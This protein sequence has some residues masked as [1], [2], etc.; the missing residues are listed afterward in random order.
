MDAK[1]RCRPEE[2]AKSLASDRFCGRRCRRQIV[3]SVVLFY[4][5]EGEKT[6]VGYDKPSSLFGQFG[7]AK[8]T[9]VAAMQTSNGTENDP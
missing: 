5:Y 9:D 1:R 3:T 4:E 7:N 8:L 6:C 2:A